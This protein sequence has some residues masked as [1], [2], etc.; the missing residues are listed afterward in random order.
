MLALAPLTGQARGC[1]NKPH[2]GFYRQGE[3][4]TLPWIF[5]AGDNGLAIDE[6]M[7]Y[8]WNLQ[9]PSLLIQGIH[10]NTFKPFG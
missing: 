9:F 4:V 3:V 7:M 6:D 8:G 2:S 10:E 1:L 5:V